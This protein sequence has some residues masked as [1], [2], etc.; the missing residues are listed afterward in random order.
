MPNPKKK[1]KTMFHFYSYILNKM[2]TKPTLMRNTFFHQLT[3]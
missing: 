1:M 2:Q 3:R